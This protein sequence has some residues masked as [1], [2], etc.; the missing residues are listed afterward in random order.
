MKRIFGIL[1]LIAVFGMLISS[2]SAEELKPYDFGNF[3]LDVPGEEW[4]YF[5][6]PYDGFSNKK[7]VSVA[8]FASDDKVFEDELDSMFST[9]ETLES[10]DGLRIYQNKNGDEYAVC[11]YTG[12]ELYIIKDKNLDEAKAIADTAKFKN[13]NSS[14]SDKNKLVSE[15]D[16]FDGLFEMD[17]P[18]VSEFEKINEE[19]NDSYTNVAFKDFKK[20]IAVNYIE[21]DNIEDLKD[22]VSSMAQNEGVNLTTEGNLTIIENEIADNS[23]YLFSVN[24]VV[25]VASSDVDL[26]TLKE[27]ANSVEFSD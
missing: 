23:V 22:Y 8:Y 9:Y 7:G 4:Q 20:N 16:A 17:V 5:N 1:I 25:E 13:P 19:G 27:M 21:S 24:K 14:D 26:E 15:S 3:T 2:V 12:D 18:K 10:E 6:A 11:K